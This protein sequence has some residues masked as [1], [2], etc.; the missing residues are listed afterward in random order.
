MKT[1]LR[2]VAVLALSATVLA[3]CLPGGD[4][5][6]ATGGESAQ[7][8]SGAV[9]GNPEDGAKQVGID[10]ENPPAA[11]AEMTMKLSGRNEVESTKIE[12]LELKRHEN[13]MLATFRLTGEG[14][15]NEEKNAHQ[16]LGYSSFQPVFIDMKKLEKYRHVDD[17]TTRPG[18][19]KAR[20]GEPIFM[21]TAF[22]LP[23][24]GVTSMDLQMTGAAAVVADIPM[25]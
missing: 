1:F 21:F 20:L 17:L 23:R 10:L 5:D 18:N 3:G 6:N 2:P 12:L 14:R 9:T 11:I 13:V 8:T 16:L 24:D 22:P 4:D 15:G 25:P 7:Q 19:V